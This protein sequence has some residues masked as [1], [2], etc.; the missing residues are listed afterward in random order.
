MNL[1]LSKS[2]FRVVLTEVLPYERPLFYSNRFFARLLKYYDVGI[3]EGRLVATRHK[4]D[5]GA[6]EFLQLLSGKIGEKTNYNYFISKD[7][8][9]KGRKLTVMHPFHQVKTMEF[10]DRYNKLMIAFCARSKFSIRYPSRISS[11]LKWSSM[12]D[13]VIDDDADEEKTSE[14]AKSFFHYEEVNNISKFYDSYKFLNIE[15]RFE[16]LLKVDIAKCFDSISPDLLAHLVYNNGINATDE[17]SGEDFIFDFIRL[18]KEIRISPLSLEDSEDEQS[19][20]GIIIGPE[21]SRIFAEIFMQQID[22][23]V[24]K[25]LKTEYNKKNPRDYAFCRYVDDSF[26]AT[27]TLD[28]LHLVKIIYSRVLEEYGLRLKE[29]K[30]TIYNQRPFIDGLSLVKARIRGLIEKT[31]E[32][33]LLTFKGFQKVQEGRYDSPMRHKFKSFISELRVLV[34]ETS[35]ALDDSDGKPAKVKLEGKSRY[36]DINSFVFGMLEKRFLKLLEEFNDL[37]REYSEGCKKSYISDGGV[38]IK[39]KYESEFEKFCIHLVESLFFILNS[40]LRMSSSISV[41]R[42]LDIIQR[43]VRGKYVFR[44]NIKSQKFRAYIISEIDEKITEET[45]KILRH[46]TIGDKYGLMEILNLLEL[47]HLMYPRNRVDEG[48]VLEFLQRTDAERQFHFFTVFQLIH[49][50]QGKKRYS[51]II[52]AIKPWLLKEYKIFLDTGGSDTESLLTV[53]ELFC[54]PEKYGIAFD[55]NELIGEVVDI[56][57]IR[58]FTDRFRSMFINWNEYSVGEEMI[59]RKGLN[60][61]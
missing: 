58:K 27:N 42:I 54:T 49:F 41:V 45:V 3:R 12:F 1:K 2:K 8:F 29:E 32:N 24:E 43:F 6:D 31:F 36:K 38:K 4:E 48:V 56:E 26:I 51:N 39:E 46:K 59:Q 23:R 53:V 37:F 28:D 35:L 15:K 7:G 33:R 61:Y 21:V 40:D 11:M 17:V 60:V 10:Y 25:I 14:S 13:K 34:A 50:T 16:F 9:D 19:D 20:K 30:M 52:E 55:M 22:I 18:H 44:G 57:R 5:E 47:Q